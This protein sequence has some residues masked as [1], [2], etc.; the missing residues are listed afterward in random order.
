MSES[1]HA[2]GASEPNVQRRSNDHGLEG[3]TPDISHM[4][5]GVIG[6]LLG[7]VQSETAKG[8]IKAAAMTAMMW[9]VSLLLV[10]V[11]GIPALNGVTLFMDKLNEGKSADREYQLKMFELQTDIE[12]KKMD[13][14]ML[15]ADAS[16]TL[17]EISKKLD[18]Q[19]AALT[20]LSDAVKG[21]QESQSATERRVAGVASRQGQIERRINQP[22]ESRP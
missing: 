22:S 3:S 4:F 11:L 21:L 20:Q 7:I 13:R 5:F 16:K 9:L 2:P 17:S 19:G 1:N 6:R 8:G 18:G 15:G 10:I 14:T 12:L